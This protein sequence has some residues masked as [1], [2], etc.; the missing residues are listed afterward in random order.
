MKYRQYN[1]RTGLDSGI[2]LVETLVA[3]AV[4]LTV[5]V[6]ATSVM[7]DSMR[8]QRYAAEQTT[9][10]YLA[11]EGIEAIRAYRDSARLELLGSNIA[12]SDN[13]FPDNCKSTNKCNVDAT[14]DI[15]GGAAFVSVNDIDDDDA[16]LTLQSGGN[17]TINDGNITLYSRLIE[18][19]KVEIDF[20]HDSD[21]STDL[22]E[23]TIYE[24]TSTVQFKL[25]SGQNG[26]VVLQEVLYPLPDFSS[27]T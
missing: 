23:T 18:F 14:G 7:F 20:D 22:V 21:G 10:S 17:Y 19:N 1:R 13:L 4:F 6:A 3:I 16:K 15:P 25:Q 8:A 27:T 9:A 26:Q 24:I 12:N 11:V 2:T 5:S